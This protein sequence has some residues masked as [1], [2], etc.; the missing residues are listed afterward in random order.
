MEVPAHKYFRMFPG[1]EVRLMGAYYATC[2][3]CE[4]DADGNI[5]VIHATYDPTQKSGQETRKVK[6]TIH[7]VNA[8]RLKELQKK[9]VIVPE[10]EEKQKEDLEKKIE[11]FKIKSDSLPEMP[12][13]EKIHNPLE[14]K[15]LDE[16]LSFDDKFNTDELFE[17]TK[18][19]PNKVIKEETKPSMEES[20]FK[21]VNNIVEE[22]TATEETPKEELPIWEPIQMPEVP[23]V[24]QDLFKEAEEIEKVE[25][26]ETKE[27]DV[28]E[29]PIPEPKEEIK[30]EI[31][32]PKKDSIYDIL[33]N[34]E[35]IIWKT[36][37]T[38]QTMNPIPVI[39]NK[40]SRKRNFG[41]IGI[42]S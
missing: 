10:K 13:E 7:W 12:L 16:M 40:K 18:I 34:N 20:L 5:T 35:N 25:F 42:R 4:K 9:T 8:E 17:N 14:N 24:T 1:N 27:P 11:E 41:R 30:E 3:G 19:V 28:V 37:E 39:E 15:T 36:T 21:E 31:I 32:E 26:P 38:K 22:E 23:E 6:G 29:Q 2:T 33:E